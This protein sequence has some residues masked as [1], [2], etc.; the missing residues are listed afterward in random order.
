MKKPR[1]PR[2]PKENASGDRWA[3]Y[4]R[5][6]EMWEDAMKE[7]KKSQQP[8]GL[9]DTIEKI[10]E[11][12]GIKKVV[13]KLF[14]EDCGCDERKA[15]VNKLFPYKHNWTVTE[16]QLVEWEHLKS[17]W[18]GPLTPQWRQRFFK[19]YNDVTSQKRQVSSCNGC[20]A[21]MFNNLSTVL[22]K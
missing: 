5:D 16:E 22:D 14:G 8:K 11:A 1:K 2:E 7:W 15:M 10:T 6:M 3:D 17:S 13:H 20:I 18:P 9:G 12:T 19:L 4:H 21:R